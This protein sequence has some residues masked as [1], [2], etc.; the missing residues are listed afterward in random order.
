MT[1]TYI[2]EVGRPTQFSKEQE[3]ITK[4]FDKIIFCNFIVVDVRQIE[5]TERRCEKCHTQNR[6]Y[7]NFST[8]VVYHRHLWSCG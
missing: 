3:N 8:Q 5:G 1:L 4:E 2:F 6:A 7:D